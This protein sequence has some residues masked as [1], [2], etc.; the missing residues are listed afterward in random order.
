MGHL[1]H[2][3]T[4]R[5]SLKEKWQVCY[6]SCWISQKLLFF[7][8]WSILSVSDYFAPFFDSVEALLWVLLL[9]YSH[10]FGLNKLL[11]FVMLSQESIICCRSQMHM[12]R[13]VKYMIII[14]ELIE[15]N[16]SLHIPRDVHS[17]QKWKCVLMLV[18]RACK[19]PIMVFRK[20]EQKNNN[21]P[22]KEW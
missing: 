15:M 6:L 19:L 17:L 16:M 5:K 8:H 22:W 13:Y 11:L 21:V 10:C 20:T 12:E 4:S 2:W 3:P 1:S 18:F 14:V 7:L 9:L